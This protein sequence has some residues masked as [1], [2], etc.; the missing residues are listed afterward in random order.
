[1]LN[2]R[3]EMTLRMNIE[4]KPNGN[5]DKNFAREHINCSN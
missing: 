3:I 2:I 1:M 5:N 4:D